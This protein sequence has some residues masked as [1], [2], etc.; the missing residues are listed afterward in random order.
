MLYRF[1]AYTGLRASELARLMP[2]A[3]NLDATPPT[4]KVRAGTHGNKKKKDALLAL[5]TDVAELMREFVAGKP[6]MVHLWQG[7]DKA[8]DESWHLH[9]ADMLRQDLEA[10]G[11]EYEDAEIHVFDFHALRHLFITNLV[12][13][14]VELQTAQN[15]GALDT[16][17]DRQRLH[18][19]GPGRPGRR[20]R[21]A[22]GGQRGKGQETTTEGGQ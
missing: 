18:L 2:A 1:A 12:R 5:L 9:G 6:K 20:P 14:G 19:P 22:A 21:Q 16:D 7:A 8:P 3:F 17:A 4:V 11:I 15:G 10:A 13:S